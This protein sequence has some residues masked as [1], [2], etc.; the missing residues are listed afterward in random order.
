MY[1]QLIDKRKP[2]FEKALEHL[3]KDL[4]A[5]RT[6][7]ASPALVE[8]ILVE[9]YGATT[10]LKNLAGITVPEARTLVIQPWDKGVL[11]AVEK[12]I[13]ASNLGI[14]PVNDGARIRL[15]LPSLNEERR[16]ELVKLVKQQAESCRVRIRNVREEI[17]KEVR[18]LLKEKKVTEDQKYDA[19][20]DL[21]K[22]VENYNE[23]I[24][25]LAEAKEKEVMT[26]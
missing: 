23:Q 12:A 21:K 1:K 3:H 7:R 6:G 17:W 10:P 5:I 22:I 20:E 9:S 4:S 2:E 16:Q 19:Q 18:K 25:N 8:N 26:V 24:K 13:A 15:N 11:T 14:T